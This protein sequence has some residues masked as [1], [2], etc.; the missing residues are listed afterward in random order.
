MKKG[1]NNAFHKRRPKYRY[2]RNPTMAVAFA[3]AVRK[4]P[5]K[6]ARLAKELGV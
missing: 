2:S 6:W 5:Q 3:N 4:E 1:L